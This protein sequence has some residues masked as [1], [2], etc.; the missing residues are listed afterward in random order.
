MAKRLY[1]GNLPYS[2]RNEGLNELF[3]QVGVVKDATVVMEKMQDATE[4]SKGFGFVE[5]E[6]DE[7]AVKAI[8]KFNGFEVEGRALRV[9]EARPR[10]ERPDR[11]NDRGAR[12]GFSGSRNRW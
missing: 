8:E 6:N 2:M 4:R 1:V 5:Y 7:D 3:S 11:G 9:D 10:E 12:G